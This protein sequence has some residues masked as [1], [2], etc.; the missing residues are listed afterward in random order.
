MRNWS[1]TTPEH[2]ELFQN[3]GQFLFQNKVLTPFLFGQHDKIFDV[4][5]THYLVNPKSVGKFLRHSKIE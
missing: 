5:I 2:N 1:E 4:A 3:I